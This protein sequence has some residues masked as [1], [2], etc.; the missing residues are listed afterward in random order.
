[1]KPK[2]ELNNLC[3]LTTT[4]FKATV[5]YHLYA[6]SPQWPR[7]LSVIDG[8]SVAIDSF[9]SVAP[10]V[11][12]LCLFLDSVS[13]LVLHHLDEEGELAALLQLSS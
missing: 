4:E 1:M 13:F 7:L 8:G 11:R 12:V 5:W 3:V 6:F 9:I 10:S 2:Y